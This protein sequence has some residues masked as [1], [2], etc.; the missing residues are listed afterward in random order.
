MLQ[1]ALYILWYKNKTN[2]LN[3]LS[4]GPEPGPIIIALSH[5]NSFSYHNHHI[6]YPDTFI[7]PFY[8]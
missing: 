4:T 7:I 5:I 6:K 2:D 3:V 1:K 8:R